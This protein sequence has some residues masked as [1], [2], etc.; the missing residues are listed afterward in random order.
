M[1]VSDEVT[2]STVSVTSGVVVVNVLEI[3]DF[4]GIVVTQTI[5]EV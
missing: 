4:R 1:K 3:T 5:S 2:V